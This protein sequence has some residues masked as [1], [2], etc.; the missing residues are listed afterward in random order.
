[1]IVYKTCISTS[2]GMSNENYMYPYD[3]VFEHDACI[4]THTHTHT[5]KELIRARVM[6]KINVSGGGTF[7]VGWLL[8][9]LFLSGMTLSTNWTR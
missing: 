2:A 3:G 4:H 8:D 5:H 1:M 7:A 9:F 6:V